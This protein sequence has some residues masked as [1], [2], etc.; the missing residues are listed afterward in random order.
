VPSQVAAGGHGA[1][2]KTDLG[3]HL[4]WPG[5]HTVWRASG[6]EILELRSLAEGMAANGC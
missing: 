1:W 6:P 2:I 3:H 5:P 4:W